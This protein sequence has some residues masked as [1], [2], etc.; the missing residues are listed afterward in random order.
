MSQPHDWPSYFEQVRRWPGIWLGRASLECLQAQ[1]LGID[2]A[3]RIHRIPEAQ[4]LAGFSLEQ[5]EVWA[6]QR[7]NPRRLSINSF[8]MARCATSSDEAAFD[9]WFSWYD[10]FRSGIEPE[11]QPPRPGSLPT[12]P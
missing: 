6:A 7:F 8:R 12:N 11:A 5:F 4:R 1:I 3:E 10:A 9:L 2:T